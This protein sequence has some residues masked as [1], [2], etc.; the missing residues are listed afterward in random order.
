MGNVFQLWLPNHSWASAS[1]WVGGK[2][3][4]H[5]GVQDG[6][7]AIQ[8]PHGPE[9][10]KSPSTRFPLSLVCLLLKTLLRISSRK[11]GQLYSAANHPPPPCKKSNCK[12]Q[13]DAKAIVTRNKSGRNGLCCFHKAGW[14]RDNSLPSLISYMRPLMWV[15]STCK[16]IWYC[17][18]FCLLPFP[19]IH[20]GPA[21]R[22]SVC[23]EDA[24]TN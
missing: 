1:R 11:L 2:L 3:H 17:R 22:Y 7:V 5:P 18:L 19:L 4:V 15:Q 24:E 8:I 6:W 23:V 9:D 16:G 21:G 12:K 14:I 10:R 20:G 13:T